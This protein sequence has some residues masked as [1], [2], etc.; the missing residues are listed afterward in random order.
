ME[1][2]LESAVGEGAEQA[3]AN[4]LP[5][6]STE[7][8]ELRITIYEVLNL[9]SVNTEKKFSVAVSAVNPKTKMAYGGGFFRI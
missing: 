1:E 9:R 8:L 2:F 4:V 3:C 5:R 7:D 6:E